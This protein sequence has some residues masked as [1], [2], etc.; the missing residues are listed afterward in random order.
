MFSEFKIQH[1]TTRQEPADIDP[2]RWIDE[3]ELTELPEISVGER[4][5]VYMETRPNPFNP[6]ITAEPD[7]EIPMILDDPEE[8]AVREGSMRGYRRRY[9]MRTRR[10]QFRLK[11]C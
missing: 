6:E 2:D 11:R 5:R 4:E 1:T 9:I 7:L 8:M 10:E 3:G